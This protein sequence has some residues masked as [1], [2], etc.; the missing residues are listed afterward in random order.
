MCDGGDDGDKKYFAIMVRYWDEEDRQAQTPFLA[1][2]V[3]N[4]PTAKALFN[5]MAS[6]LDSQRILWKSVIKFASDSTS[7]MVEVRNSVPSRNRQQQ[8]EVFSLG[9]LC[10]LAALCAA[11]ALKKL[12]VSVGNLLVDIFY[13]FKYSA[14]RWTTWTEL[15]EFSHN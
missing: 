15:P 11:A 1:M 14:K 7:V 2:L 3:C 5:A 10:H 6:K 8:P 12:P 4:D 9:C 13:H